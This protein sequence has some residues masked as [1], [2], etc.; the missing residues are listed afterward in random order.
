MKQ[1]EVSN[2]GKKYKVTARDSIAAVA[3]V[4]RINDDRLSPMTYKKLKELGYNSNDW[5]N[6][7][8]EQANAVV[9]KGENKKNKQTQ[10][11][12]TQNSGSSGQTNNAPK[13]KRISR[14][15]VEN[16][17]EIMSDNDW[18][19]NLAV[20]SELEDVNEEDIDEMKDIYFEE[21]GSEISDD[22]LKYAFK[23]MRAAYEEE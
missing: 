6:W 22:E 5:K 12:Q 21:T 8:Q 23:K 18:M 11:N 15:R 17:M 9:E 16:M 1:F 2:K 14:K 10:T 3:A 7:T 13:A 4:M 20:N 19:W